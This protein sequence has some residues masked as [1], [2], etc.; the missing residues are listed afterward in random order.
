MNDVLKMAVK[1][2]VDRVPQS[3][4]LYRACKRYVDRHN[5]E[6]NPDILTNGELCFMR[7][8]LPGSQT[9]FDVGANIGEWTSLALSIK[10]TLDI[11]CFEPSRVTF[12]KLLDKKFPPNVACNHFGLG[13]GP[14]KARL[15][16]FEE[17]AG[18]NSL[19]RRDGLQYLGLEPQAQV[20][21]IELDSIDNYCGRR[22]I[23][24]IDFLKLDVEGHELE[25]FKGMSNLLKQGKVKAIQFEY[26]GCNIDARVFLKDIWTY[27]KP[28]PYVFYKLYPDGHR[29]VTTYSQVL[30]NF[31][32]QN[33]AL[34]REGA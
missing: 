26:G 22:H 25:V 29:R 10:P 13:S 14:T 24:T 18:T 23:E 6:N 1:R 15:F 17:G 5:G 9:V 11:H 4:W 16:V 3:E 28:Y 27:F 34:I 7:D 2:I 8:F 30:E 20:E 31:Q 19:Y 21:T 12:M 32:Y 33:W